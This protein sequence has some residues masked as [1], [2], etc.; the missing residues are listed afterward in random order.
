M[1]KLL[2]QNRTPGSLS[3]ALRNTPTERMES[4]SA[5]ELFSRRMNIVLST[6]EELLKPRVVKHVTQSLEKETQARSY[7]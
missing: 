4:S 7:N 2:L 5:Q 6:K 3:V 1:R